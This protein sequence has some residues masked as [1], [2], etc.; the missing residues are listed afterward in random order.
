MS[1]VPTRAV[2]DVVRTDHSTFINTVTIAYVGMT[3]L[4]V[5]VLAFG[6]SCFQLLLGTVDDSVVC[7]DWS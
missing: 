7:L 2:G 4:E 6:L 5:L 3:F 1:A